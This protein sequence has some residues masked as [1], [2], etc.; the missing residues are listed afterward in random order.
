MKIL[1]YIKNKLN[2]TS[3]NSID[4]NLFDSLYANDESN[5]VK[6]LKTDDNKL[7]KLFYLDSTKIKENIKELALGYSDEFN[8][9]IECVNYL[10]ILTAFVSE[11][12]KV[13]T[14]LKENSFVG[15]SNKEFKV[16]KYEFYF[17]D[18]VV[19]Y[20]ID[21]Q[22]RYMKV[23]YNFSM[24]FDDE[25]YENESKIMRKRGNYYE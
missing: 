17:K 19:E 11:M 5:N 23:K 18:D 13:A 12:E 22:T 1:D 6:N 21:L 16:N 7:V 2:N 14:N 25:E 10:D 24:V 15:N 4:K 3:D 20:T 9:F 8:I